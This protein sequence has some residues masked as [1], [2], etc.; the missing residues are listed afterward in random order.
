[1]LRSQV[2][3]LPR[4][5]GLLGVFQRSW[6]RGKFHGRRSCIWTIARKPLLSNGGM[7]KSPQ[8]RVKAKEQTVRPGMVVAVP[9]SGVYITKANVNQRSRMVYVLTE[10]ARKQ[11]AFHRKRNLGYNQRHTYNVYLNVGTCHAFFV[12]KRYSYTTRY[13]SR[14]LQN[15]TLVLRINSSALERRM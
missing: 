14:R 3:G 5:G 7:C 15:E 6:Q 9:E 8:L 11:A 4:E 13:A 12:C 10:D 1:M 2:S